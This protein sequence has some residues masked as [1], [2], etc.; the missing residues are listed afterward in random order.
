[1]GESPKK[2]DDLIKE[3]WTR[4][5]VANEPRLSEAV[6]LYLSMGHEIHLKPL[7]LVDCDSADEE[8]GECRACFKGFEDQYKIIYTRQKRGESEE[9]DLW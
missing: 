9:D 4:R 8:S 6:E 1:M 5:F 7:P 2:A 3:G